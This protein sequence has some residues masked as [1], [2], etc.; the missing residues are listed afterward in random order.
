M[1][2]SSDVSLT[3]NDRSENIDDDSST[4]PS[5]S[6]ARRAEAAFAWTVIVSSTIFS[7]ATTRPMPSSA[8][9]R[10]RIWPLTL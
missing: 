6:P 3:V 2:G 1:Y 5:R 10:S 4:W 9:N 7:S 8:A